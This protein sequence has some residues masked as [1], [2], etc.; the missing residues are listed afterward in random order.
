MIIQAIHDFRLTTK[1]KV[2]CL[3]PTFAFSGGAYIALTTDTIYMDH[4][5]CLSPCD[6]QLNILGFVQLSVAAIKKVLNSN[7]SSTS[8][9][10]MKLCKEEV[11]PIIKMTDDIF[12]TYVNYSDDIKEKLKQ[13]FISGNHNHESVISKLQAKELGLNVEN[14]TE[15]MKKAIALF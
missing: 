12:N 3:I 6:P 15:D 8:D 7:A 10:V 5:S 11:D 9:F 4:C 14:S 13:Q 1:K 2:N